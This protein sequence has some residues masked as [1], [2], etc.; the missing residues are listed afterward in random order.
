M[1]QLQILS[2]KPEFPELLNSK[3]I[4]LSGSI[5]LSSRTS[6]S[7]GAKVSPAEMI[8]SPEGGNTSFEG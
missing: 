4:S 1:S 8:T 2:L 5:I 6:K 3:N 7:R